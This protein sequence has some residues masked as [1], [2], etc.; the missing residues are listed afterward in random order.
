MDSQK[1]LALGKALIQEAF[2]PTE[3]KEQDVKLFFDIREKV[4]QVVQTNSSANVDESF[5][6]IKKVKIDEKGRI[7]IPNSLRSSFPNANYLPALRDG[8]LYILII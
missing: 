2:G 3:F 6:F 5:Y 8:K 7:I 4:L 1:R